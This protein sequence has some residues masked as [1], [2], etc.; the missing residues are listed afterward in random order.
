MANDIMR[1]I[2]AQEHSAFDMRKIMDEKKIL[3]INLSK[4]RLGDINSSLIG[5]IIVGKILMAA[6]SRVD[7]SEDE[8]ND[9]Y[10]EKTTNRLFNIIMGTKCCWFVDKRALHSCL[11]EH[12]F[13]VQEM[14]Y[15]NR[16]S[17]GRKPVRILS[18][19]VLRAC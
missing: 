11:F 2:V 6:L 7:I 5:L 19:Q 9:F 12:Y 8:R 4:G 16:T 14:L 3:L 15:V 1:P 17:G 13:T 18:R 10:F